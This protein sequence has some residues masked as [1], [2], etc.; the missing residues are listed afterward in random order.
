MYIYLSGITFFATKNMAKRRIDEIGT[1][2]LHYPRWYI[3]T[4]RWTKR[5]F[6]INKSSIPRYLYAELIVSL[7]FL[8]MGPINIVVFIISNYN[9]KIGSFL[10]CLHHLL[11]VIVIAFD[12]IMTFIIKKE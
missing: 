7:F 4:P 8:C 9:Q 1:Y 12:C 2:S 5:C 10:V 11:A 6:G 3:N